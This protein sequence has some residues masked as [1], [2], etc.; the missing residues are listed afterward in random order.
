MK[1]T[2][3]NLIQNKTESVHTS[4]FIYAIMDELSSEDKIKLAVEE[5]DKV[6]YFVSIEKEDSF[7]WKNKKNKLIGFINYFKSGL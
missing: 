4:S 6:N 3:Y 1:D 2:L 7:Y 5:L